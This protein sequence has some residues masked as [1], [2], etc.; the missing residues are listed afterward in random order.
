MIHIVLQGSDV[1][2]RIDRVEFRRPAGV[3][4]V[5]SEGFG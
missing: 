1:I 5:L 2:M 4:D 3:R